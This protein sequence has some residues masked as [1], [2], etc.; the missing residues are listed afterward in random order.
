MAD[1]KK[2]PIDLR[3]RI[4]ARI[5]R[6]WVPLCGASLLFAVLTGL[7][8]GGPLAV[9]YNWQTGKFTVIAN[10]KGNAETQTHTHRQLLA[11]LPA[12]PNPLAW[13]E[14]GGGQP[15]NT[16]A[17]LT[18]VSIA[19]F[20]PVNN[21][22]RIHAGVTPPGGQATPSN[23]DQVFT[24]IFDT[25]YDAIRV[26]CVV[27]CGGG[28]G[29]PGGGNSAVQFNSSGSFSGDTTNFYYNNTTHSLGV[30]G[31]LTL[32]SPLGVLSGGTGTTT[33][34]LLAGSNI[35]VTGTWPGQMVALS[36][37]LPATRSAVT[38]NWIASYNAATGAFAV[39]QPTFL[40]LGG[41]AS[42]AQ[43]ATAYSGVGACSANTWAST[44]IRNTAPTCTQPA[45]SNIAGSVAAS[46]LPGPTTT[47]LGG[48]QA[49]SPISHQWVNSISTSGIPALSQPTFA[50]VSGT[51]SLTQ[52]PLVIPQYAGT[53]TAGDCAKWSSGGVLA[54]AG[55][56]CGSGSTA[57]GGG[58]TAVQFNSSGTFGGDTAN[59]YYNTTTHSLGVTGGMTLGSPLGVSSGGT[60]TTTPN[61][62]AGQNISIG[63]AW[64]DQTVSLSGVI[65]SSSLPAPTS[66]TLGGVESVGG[67][68]HEWI[69]S[70]SASGAPVLSQ[71][72]FSDISGTASASQLPSPAGDVT[73]AFGG[74][75]VTGL[76]FG[77]TGIA[78]GT[79][80]ASG[81]CLAYN[82]SNI[83][84]AACSGG[85]GSPGGSNSQFQFNN[86]NNFGGGVP[87]YNSSTAE[88]TF[89][90]INNILYVDGVLYA[91]ASAAIAAL[92]ASGGTVIDNLVSD[93]WNTNPFQLGA[94]MISSLS[95]A[96]NVA[97]ATLT[98]TAP[99]SFVVGRE[100]QVT[101]ASVAAYDGVWNI[102]TA[103][104]TTVTFNI[105]STPANATG[106]TITGLANNVQLR[107]GAGTYSVNAQVIVPSGSQIKAQ[108]R[109][110]TT[111]QPGASFPAGTYPPQT[112]ALTSLSESGTTVT[113]SFAGTS[114]ASWF[115]AGKANIGFVP[116][117]GYDANGV[118]ITLGTCSGGS[119][120]FSYT[121]ASG[122][123]ASSG[124]WVQIPE[125][126]PTGLT[127]CG[128]T[129]PNGTYYFVYTYRN[130]NGETTT[131]AQQSFAINCG[132]NNTGSYV[133][134]APPALA[135]TGANA[136]CGTQTPCNWN[137]YVGTTSGGPYFFQND[138]PATSGLAPTVTTYS[139][140]A[141][142]PYS[143]SASPPS[144]NTTGAMF[145]L[146]NLTYTPAFASR[147]EHTTLSCGSLLF[148]MGVYN[149]SAQEQSGVNDV[150]MNNCPGGNLYWNTAT[151]QDSFIRNVHLAN[152]PAF[153]TMEDVVRLENLTNFPRGMHNVTVAASATASAYPANLIHV[154][155]PANPSG[156][157]SVNVDLYDI[158]LEGAGP[159]GGPAYTDGIFLDGYVSGRI[160]N[161]T[162]ATS[163]NKVINNLIHLGANNHDVTVTNITG[164]VS[165]TNLLKDDST[166]HTITEASSESLASY[167]IGNS[168]YPNTLIAGLPNFGVSGTVTAGDCVKFG[169]ATTLADAGA[170]CG[171]GGGGFTAG[172]DLGG[173]TTSQ[174]VI[175][176]QSHAVSSTAPS[177]GQVLEWT[178]TAWTPSINTPT[179]AV[180]QSPAN[181]TTNVI[182]P[183]IDTPSLLLNPFSSTQISD[184][185]DVKGYCSGTLAVA[186]SISINGNMNFCGNR[187]TYGASGQGTYSDILLIGGNAPNA[188]PFVSGETAA[189]TN[190]VDLY[191]DS[192]RT[193]VFVDSVAGDTT[194][195][196]TSNVT[197]PEIGNT[198]INFAHGLSANK[199]ATCAVADTY[200]ATDATAGA[201]LYF[202]TVANTWTLASGGGGGGGGGT[203]TSVGL[204][205]PSIFAL[206]GSPVTTSGTLTG[207][208]APET[209]NT[210]FAGPASGGQAA[211]TFRSLAAADLAASPINGDC[212]QYNGT[213]LAWAACGSGG[214]AAW[215]GITSPT[216]NLTLSMAGFTTTFNWTN[217]ALGEFAWD[218]NGNTTIANT[219][220]ATATASVSSPTFNLSGQYWNGTATAADTWTWHDTIAAGTNGVP[221]LALTH[222]GSTG[223]AKLNLPNNLTIA[224]LGGL[225]AVGEVE[226]NVLASDSGSNP[227]KMVN[228]TGYSYTSSGTI[229][230][231]DIVC[232]TATN[233]TVADCPLGAINW[234]GIAAATTGFINVS[235]AG[236]TVTAN[237]DAATV[238]T[239][240]VACAP[241][242]STGTVGKLHDNG[243]TACAIGQ[244]VGIITTGG[245]ASTG[246][247]LI[248]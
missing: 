149:E 3:H 185:L 45:F 87:T 179:G 109:F 207:S 131:S 187:S 189:G 214:A 8:F 64:P 241:I 219:E 19:A 98:A 221:T 161:V 56:A 101:G 220:A 65:P 227:I 39:A 110:A 102:A 201:N 29:A 120:S 142:E 95:A 28:G 243:T 91:S 233:Q 160:S 211:P 199:P 177:T 84:G 13:L 136:T 59:F 10:T 106:G 53:I 212:L 216:A 79:A 173:T 96:S 97:T 58:S 114:F 72:A 68:A 191:F 46:Q 215:S 178:G 168:A 169:T 144:Y 116:V 196:V 245:T 61:L 239:G 67:V 248:R 81:Q 47:T 225:L 17:G 1:L 202:C 37:T 134:P 57:P 54:D 246:I 217:P 235:T 18:Q 113:A 24:S 123:A 33:P 85:S 159:V 111:L 70:I 7:L 247:I 155:N 128:G 176:I 32:G 31:G 171:S 132:T 25:T 188:Q 77:S 50:D 121:A 43:L 90:N 223:S 228:S 76:H 36:G 48:I 165:V 156:Y 100:I 80:P 20:D 117:M 218:A 105:G 75:T 88:S 242:A 15:Q 244:E 204:A 137:L 103:S 224:S 180:V 89:P 119:C 5:S 6:L 122:L 145:A 234:I 231:G 27:G 66:S 210:V 11:L 118:T 14:G 147:I 133:P 157:Y 226:A 42:D 93:T 186:F 112:L 52:L 51:V 22:L 154:L 92:P 26:N 127:A 108:S 238:T 158:H 166:G 146:G 198:F 181:A 175:G 71:P 126:A 16:P 143:Q 115:V 236:G 104:G 125:T 60:G 150:S 209:A 193:G 229:A 148:G 99:T 69:N 82:G 74:T 172:G 40:N 205:L 182:T 237:F 200:F 151:A 170:A 206:S 44:L 140:I 208:L 197:A 138:Y 194:P 195:P 135:T 63:G 86:N 30:T 124:G 9:Y 107:L 230:A 129:I 184:V 21:A 62:V 141:T 94:A 222:A 164:G 4:I 167:A 2:S 163:G 130:P 12:G 162:A 34:S 23:A 78:L 240:D 174:T 55:A 190:P 183:T 41:T 139:T 73:G 152:G 49:V 192:A 232:M 38:N 203:V 153:Q 213:T 35:S 83:T